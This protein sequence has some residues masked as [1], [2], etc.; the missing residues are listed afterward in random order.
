MDHSTPL[1]NKGFVSETFDNEIVLYTVTDT[2]AIYLN[3][4]AHLIWKL[5]EDKQSVGAI[6]SLLEESYPGHSS[7]IRE[8]VLETLTALSEIGAISFDAPQ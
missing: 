8:Q 5:C 7:V 3:E 6:I 2:K 1:V 4:T